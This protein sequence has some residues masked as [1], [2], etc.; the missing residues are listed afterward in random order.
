[1]GQAEYDV[2]VVGARCA[3]SPLAMLLAR[4]GY[5]I[6]LVDRDSFPSDT[7]SS[8]LVYQ[9]GLARMQRWGLLDRLEATGCPPL[10]TMVI[11]LGIA[12]MEGAP[13]PVDGVAIM[14][15]PRRTVLDNLLVDAAIEAG[16]EFQDRC[17]VTDLVWENGRAAGVRVRMDGGSETEINAALVVG[18][19]GK[20]S[21]VARS[22]KS[23]KYRDEGSRTCS[24]YSYW[25]GVTPGA[26]RNGLF[27]REDW[28]IAYGP[29]HDGLVIANM[30]AALTH[31]AS[32]RADIEATFFRLLESGIPELAEMLRSGSRAERFR[33]LA[34]I[35]NFFRQSHGPGWA[36]AGDAGY[37]RDP[38]TAQG[39]SDSFRDAD[40]LAEAIDDGLGG[41]VDL[42]ASLAEYARRRDEDSRET[43]DWTLA[44]TTFIGPEPTTRE[45][46][47][48]IASDPG[49]SQKFVNLNQGLA[50]IGDVI[51][52][53]AAKLAA[54]G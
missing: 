6:L 9:T 40:L 3:G 34:E 46:M 24:Y 48:A 51:S 50:T 27:A 47:Q 29:T 36:L 4:K 30:S 28:G 8:H 45:L 38:I 18:A 19:D 49:L 21:I 54:A 11:D 42:D 31:L 7:I 20:N 15:C 53:G 16:A 14:Y 17:S 35:P 13:F 33:G 39:I 23:S 2:I 32:F 43:F 26:V 41:R 44:C 5:R 37:Y 10:D 12:V 52:G 22:V 25:S 1:V